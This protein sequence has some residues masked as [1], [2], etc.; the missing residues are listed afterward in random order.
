MNL[1]KLTTSILFCVVVTQFSFSQNVNIPDVNFKTALLNHDPVI[2]TNGDDEIQVS[3]ATAYAG[4]LNLGS[5]DISDLTGIE[6]FVSIVELLCNNNEI[7]AVDLSNN[8][9]LQKIDIAANELSILDVSQN[10]NL[11]ELACNGNNITELNTSLNPN[12]QILNV[13][14]NSV[15]EL[16]LSANIALENLKLNFTPIVDLDITNNVNLEVFNAT[17]CYSLNTVD[18]S[19]NNLLD[20]YSIFKHS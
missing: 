19:N 3:E 13:A 8:I 6:S 4:S 1:L 5:L 17:Y 15:Y 9:A 12:L 10:I 7:V 20:F 14:A 11:Q 16:D 18:F 2:D